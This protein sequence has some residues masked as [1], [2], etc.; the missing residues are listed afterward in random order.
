[1]RERR[2]PELAAFALTGL[3]LLFIVAPVAVVVLGSVL[4]ARWLGVSS[5]QWVAAGNGPVT[6]EWFG[7]VLATYGRMLLFSLK[8]AL[9]SVAVCVAVGV[10]AAYALVEH[11]FPGSALV[12]EIVLV[13]LSLP[14]IT[15]SI[16]LIQAWAVW[17]GSWWLV[18]SG[19][20]LYTLPFMV[21][22]TSGALRSFDLAVLERAART[23]GA[24]FFQRF[25]LVVLPSLKH[26]ILVGS[27]LVF[28]IS[29]GEFNVS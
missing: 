26:A 4:N 1:M 10:P 19:H 14:G 2:L 22:V 27:L 15:L 7:Y 28:A 6:F 17:R 11:P 29:W 8:L 13:P 16:A 9:L 5:E 24:G 12:E 18:L 23:L 25:V 21:R 20:L 3:L